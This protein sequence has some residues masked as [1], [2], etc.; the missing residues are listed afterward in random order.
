MI[1]SYK[2]L[3]RVRFR[4]DYRIK[5]HNPLTGYFKQSNILVFSLAAVVSRWNVYRVILSTDHNTPS[6]LLRNPLLA[7]GGLW[8]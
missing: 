7:R 3:E 5:P 2:K 8:N 4:V 6:L 1:L